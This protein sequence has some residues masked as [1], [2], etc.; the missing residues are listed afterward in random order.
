MEANLEKFLN[1]SIKEAGKIAMRGFRSNYRTGWKSRFDPVTPTDLKINDYLA[2][3]IR[4]HYPDHSIISEEMPARMTGS[5]YVW[6]I[7]PIDGTIPFAQGLPYFCISIGLARNNKMILAAVL[8]PVHDE[9][10]FAERGKGAYLNGRKIKSGARQKLTAAYVDFAV[11]RAAPYKLIDFQNHLNKVCYVTS[12]HACLVLS[13]C[14]VAVGRMDAT[15]FAGD[16][17]WDVAAASLICKEAG[18]K[19]TNLD[20]SNWLP[21]EKPIGMIAARPKL[22]LELCKLAKRKIKM[23]L[24]P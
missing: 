23:D 8:D 3:R 4:K 13:T 1:S 24:M 9:L 16:T 7:D 19:C 2:A 5:E 20:G 17:P 14:N 6:Y 21:G 22:H 12:H 10:F 18:A 11:W 15:V